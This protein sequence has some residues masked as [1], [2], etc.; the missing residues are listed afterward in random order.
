MR[1][2]YADLCALCAAADMPISDF[3]RLVEVIKEGEPEPLVKLYGR[4]RSRIKE[5]KSN[6]EQGHGSTR[7]GSKDVPVPV[8]DVL[9][10]ANTVDVP[11]ARFAKLIGEEALR[12][13]KEVPSN[14]ILFSPKQGFSKWLTRLHRHIG[15]AALL[16]AASRA[17]SHSSGGL[18]AHQWRLSDQ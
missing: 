6:L 18:T 9:K 7:T 12:S 16:A 3:K 5:V 17:A 15:G 8:Q 2:V 11:T 14:I 10:L 13:G 4:A 1:D